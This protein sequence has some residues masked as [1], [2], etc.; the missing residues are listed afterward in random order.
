MS[1]EIE[2]TLGLS[3]TQELEGCLQEL[4]EMYDRQDIIAYAG[5]ADPADTAQCIAE[6]FD[7]ARAAID[8]PDLEEFS[9]LD[10]EF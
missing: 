4:I 8:S 7:R 2:I 9:L 1:D 6:A 10:E 5:G 3:R